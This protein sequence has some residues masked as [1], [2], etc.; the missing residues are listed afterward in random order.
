MKVALVHYWLTGMRGGEKVLEEFSNLFPDA[1]IFTLV[2]DEKSVSAKL[3][4]HKVTTSF[5]QRIGGVKHYQKMLPLMPFALESFDLTEYDLVIS[6]EAG[7][8]KGIVTR[9]D[10][11]HVCYCHSPMRYIWDLFPQYRKSAGTIARTVMSISAPLLRVWDVTT[12]HRVDHFIANSSYVA[13]RI[14]KFYRRDAHVIHPPVNIE[15]FSVADDVGDYYLC[16]GQI[17]PYKKIELAV[18][19]CNRL[20]KRLVVIGGG[21]T[22]KLRDLGGKNVEFLGAVDDA[23]MSHHFQRCRALLYPGVEDFGIVPLEVMAS[24]RPVIAFNRGGAVETVVHGKTGLLFNEQSV[25]S[26]CGAITQLESSLSSFSPSE[27]RAHA[28]KFDGLRFRSELIK[29]FNVLGVQKLWGDEIVT[30][31]KATGT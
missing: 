7:P 17:T 31:P 12:S 9:P 28:L 5:L 18:E 15:R 6:S 4:K 24:G 23:T 13:K 19:A 27:M 21:V 2:Y 29:F 11:I 16:A 25:E 14:E 20:N 8:A 10:A 22:Q 3:A 30:M 1:D 26:L